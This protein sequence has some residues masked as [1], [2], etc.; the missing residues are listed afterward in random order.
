MTMTGQQNTGAQEKEA[1]STSDADY[2]KAVLAV[3]IRLPET[4]RRANSHDR[5]VAR[6]L[7]ARGVPL[8]IV[9]A[10]M[11]L[12]SLRRF[13]RPQA[14]LPLA[15]IR[16]LAYF[17]A[18]IDELEQQSMPAGYLS[19]LRYKAGQIFPPTAAWQH[20]CRR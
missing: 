14:A 15:R 8:D 16:S 2:W 12:G 7:W 20:G 5:A 3:Y 10:A 19:H 11:L 6:S 1:A 4:P 13:T 9:E 17:S 18:V